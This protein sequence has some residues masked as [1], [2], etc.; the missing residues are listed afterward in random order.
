MMTARE[1]MALPPGGRVRAL[2]RRAEAAVKLF[3]RLTFSANEP[4]INQLRY[5]GHHLACA[6]AEEADSAARERQVDMAGR[7]CVRAY[8]DALDGLLVVLLTQCDTFMETYP[9]EEVLRVL[10]DYA[11][12]CA[13]VEAVRQRWKAFGRVQA[14]GCETITKRLHPLAKRLSDVLRDFRVAAASLDLRRDEAIR[15]RE[16]KGDR[17][18]VLSLMVSFFGLVLSLAVIALYDSLLLPT[19]IVSALVVLCHARMDDLA[20]ERILRWTVYG[21]A[22]LLVCLWVACLWFGKA[23]VMAW[24]DAIP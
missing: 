11:R 8:Y 17:Q 1:I 18:F 7:H 20:I 13:E 16:Q 23:R 14:M 19:L 15:A 2:F 4:A 9:R 10:P 3:E 5:A 6:M 12:L 24:L 22:A 21:L